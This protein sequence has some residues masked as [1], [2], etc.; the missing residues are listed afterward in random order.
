MICCHKSNCCLPEVQSGCI[1]YRLCY[2]CSM[3]LRSAVRNSR[4][5]S[6]LAAASPAWASN[7][8]LAHQGAWWRAAWRLTWAGQRST[9]VRPPRDSAVTRRTRA[10]SLIT[11][12]LKQVGIPKA[13]FLK[14]MKVYLWHI[15]Y[16]LLHLTYKGKMLRFIQP[17]WLFIAFCCQW[18]Q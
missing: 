17:I 7:P 15:P 6:S 4:L 2:Y 14:F 1:L 16:I 3:K 12:L 5:W 13:F 18:W 11:A 10:S 9:R 8:R